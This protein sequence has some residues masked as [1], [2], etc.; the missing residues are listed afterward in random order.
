MYV[1]NAHK[2]LEASSPQRLRPPRKLPTFGHKF[3]HKTLK[4]LPPLG[5]AHI[6]KKPTKLPTNYLQKTVDSKE[7][8]C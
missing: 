6:S 5:L 7:F 2:P 4:P 1:H 8:P 3:T